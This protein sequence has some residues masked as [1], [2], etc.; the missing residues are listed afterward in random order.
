MFEQEPE[1][2]ATQMYTRL[3]DILTPATTELEGTQSMFD[4]VSPMFA[5]KDEVKPTATHSWMGLVHTPSSSR[6]SDD[7]DHGPSTGGD[8]SVVSFMKAEP[9]H[10]DE[11]AD[12][13]A[14]A[15]VTSKESLPH[16]VTSDTSAHHPGI[17]RPPR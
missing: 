17:L 2:L 8:S 4:I 7:D 3:M 14:P 10:G 5:D 15:P 6:R 13:R 16:S 1:D 11:G 12:G 9:L